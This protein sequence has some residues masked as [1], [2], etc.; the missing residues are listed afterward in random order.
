MILIC[1][2]CSNSVLVRGVCVDCEEPDGTCVVFPCNYLR[3]ILN[4][5]KNDTWFS[6]WSGTNKTKKIITNKIINLTNYHI[7]QIN[8]K[9]NES[10]RNNN[11]ERG[12]S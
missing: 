7:V 4:Q 1:M 2:G 3:V 12:I 8:E 6:I 9:E 5:E 11:V 10:R